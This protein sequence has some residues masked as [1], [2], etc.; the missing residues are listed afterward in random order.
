ML[1]IGRLLQLS[2]II[3]EEAQLNEAREDFVAQ[4]LG[5]K[6]TAAY[7]ND[8][9]QKP[10]LDTP[11]AIVQYV[12]QNTDPKAIQK[13]MAWYVAGQFKLED[14]HRIKNDLTLFNRVK[15]QLAVKDLN[16]YKTLVDL[17]NALAPFENQDVKTKGEQERE[18]KQSGAK[19]IINSP[20]FKV[21]EILNKEAACYYGKGTKW[22]TAADEN[23][24]F[25]HYHKQG[26]IYIIT[27]PKINRKWQLHYESG[28]YMDEQDNQ[29]G[30][31]DIALLSKVPEY[32]QFLNMLI[33]KHYPVE[34]Q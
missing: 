10:P 8:V 7:N 5:D 18:I 28:Q 19:T 23:N 14:V 27:M 21:I 22:C 20:D 2:G 34:N 11:L 26:S 9:G 31:A 12:S 6:I 30:S 3:T 29:I 24:M 32:T 4:Q 25:D 33:K 15:Q 13:L 17:Y 16:Q 1:E